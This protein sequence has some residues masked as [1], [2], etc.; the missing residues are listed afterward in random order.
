MYL[1]GEALRVIQY[2]CIEYG[3]LARSTMALP[4]I[5]FPPFLQKQQKHV[6]CLDKLTNLHLGHIKHVN[7]L[8]GKFNL[9]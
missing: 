1:T 7:M 3:W 5:A 6:I 8:E 4:N 9:K 2:L